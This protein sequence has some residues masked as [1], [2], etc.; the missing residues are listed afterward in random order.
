MAWLQRNALTF[1]A[2]IIALLVVAPLA[3]MVSVSFRAPGAAAQF[4]PP[5]WPDDPTLENYTTLF[6]TYGI[7]R[8]FL[9]SVL[10]SCLATVLALLFTVPAG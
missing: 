10:V 4:P 5:L 6:G 8:Y 1:L 3:W 7:G 9:N 2:A